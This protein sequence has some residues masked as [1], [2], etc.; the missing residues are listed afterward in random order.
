M[1][2]ANGRPPISAEL[3]WLF[4]ATA[5][6]IDLLRAQRDRLR[7]YGITLPPGTLSILHSIRTDL[8]GLA[9]QI[10]A[11]SV[12]LDQ[13]RALAE[14]TALL[15]SSL[16]L[17]QV[18]NEVMDK[19]IALTRAERGY[20]VLRDPTGQMEPCGAQPGPRDDRR[21]RVH[22]QPDGRGGGRGDR[23]AGRHDERPSGP[24]FSSQQ[25]VMPHALRSICACRCW[26]K[27]R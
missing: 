17:N 27:A 25:S 20:I 18:L 23:A 26:S 12:E 4:S 22:R 7:P 15:N 8:E 24:R 3:E 19:V 16:D 13:L 14:T 6:M 5:E 9:P 21:G 10:T 11:T 2:E 1:V